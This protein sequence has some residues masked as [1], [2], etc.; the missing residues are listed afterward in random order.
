MKTVKFQKASDNNKKVLSPEAKS[1]RRQL[2]VKFNI[3][4]D[5]LNEQ[6]ILKIM[7]AIDLEVKDNG[8]F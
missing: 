5:K 2:K 3:D 8:N 6:D 7:T 4:K 1:K